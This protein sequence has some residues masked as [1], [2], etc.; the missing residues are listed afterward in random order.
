[1]T[2]RV[3]VFVDGE[4]ISAD[5]ADAI[6]RIA[7]QMGSPDILRVYGNATLLPG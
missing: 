6:R 2:G 5:H 4:N 1:M 7:M 3:A